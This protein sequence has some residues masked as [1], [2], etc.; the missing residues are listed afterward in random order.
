M[1]SEEVEKAWRITNNLKT[2]IGK[3]QRYFQALGLVAFEE[4]LKKREPNLSVDLTQVSLLNSKYSQI[5][6]EINAVFNL[7]V[8]KF[9]VCLISTSSFSDDFI[10]IPQSVIDI[11]EF[12]AHF[13]IIV[14]VEDELEVAAIRGFA[15]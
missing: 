3:L 15:R 2:E 4:W 13:Y 5:I 10:D 14:G 7:Q 11:P 1:E 8:G 6:K 9:K 12:A